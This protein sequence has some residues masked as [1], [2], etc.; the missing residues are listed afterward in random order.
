MDPIRNDD[1]LA[2]LVAEHGELAVEPAEDEFERFVVS[3]VNQQLSTQS[4]AAIRDRLFERFEVTPEAMLAAEEDALRDVGLS[5]QK[6][7]YVRSVATAF[8]EDDL[9][10]EGLAHLSDEE[11]LARLT[12]IRGVGDWTAKM[13]L[14]FVLAREDVFPVEDLGIRKA[15]AKLYGIDEDDRTA[16][17][18]RAEAWRPHRTLASR[19]LWRS[20]D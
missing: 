15:M 11:A 1:R 2:E 19:Y 14:M 7:S 4:A 20:V 10:R 16:M 5:S 8:Q 13:Y 12:E 18:D 3:I 6:I 9:T 17:V